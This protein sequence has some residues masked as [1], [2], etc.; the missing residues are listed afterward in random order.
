MDD[1]FNTP[2]ALAILQALARELNSAKAAGHGDQAAHLAAELRSLGAVLGL[3]GLSPDAWL[4]LPAGGTA[5]A[6]GGEA[7]AVL[8]DEEI[9]R[10]IAARHLARQARNWGESD[11]IRDELARAGVVLE[12]KPGGKTSWRRD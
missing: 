7:G 12:D 10:Y 11:R 1:D 9:E 4:R 6:P 3:V 2:E 8:S 5:P